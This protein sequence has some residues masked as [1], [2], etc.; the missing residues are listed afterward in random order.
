[1]NLDIIGTCDF[2]D[3]N[4]EIE[5]V[6]Q[7]IEGIEKALSD[8]NYEELGNK[9]SDALDVDIDASNI[10][11]LTSGYKELENNL[12]DLQAVSEKYSEAV[13]SYTTLTEDLLHKQAA[14]NEE[15]ARAASV[16]DGD[17]M[18]KCSQELQDLEEATQNA[19]DKMEEYSSLQDEVQ[20]KIAAT[21]ERLAQMKSAASSDSAITVTVQDNGVAGVTQN[22]QELS[23]G[24]EDLRTKIASAKDG[25]TIDLSGASE[26]LNKIGDAL[27]NV[28]PSAQEAGQSMSELETLINSA[29][30]MYKQLQDALANLQVGDT[31]Q[32][33]QYGQELETLKNVID[34]IN[35]LAND[36]ILV[37]GITDISAS[38]PKGEGYGVLENNPDVKFEIGNTP[39]QMPY[40]A[41]QIN[42][43]NAAQETALEQWQRMKDAIQASREEY[44]RFKEY[45]VTGEDDS[46]Q[47]LANNNDMLDSIQAHQEATSKE[48]EKT[49][50]VFRAI[51]G[52]IKALEDKNKDLQ[53][54][55]ARLKEA[56]ITAGDEVM[57]MGGENGQAVAALMKSPLPAI[58]QSISDNDA[59]IKS[60]TDTLLEIAK[61][62]QEI[63][64]ESQVLGEKADDIKRESADI[65]IALKNASAAPKEADAA[66]EQTVEP[67]VERFGKLKETM[68]ELGGGFGQVLG[69]FKKL[70]SGGAGAVQGIEMITAGF[71]QMGAAFLANPI[72]A[73][74]A[75]IVVAFKQ[76][77]D[78]FKRN[79]DAMGALRAVAAPFKAVWQSIQRLFDDIVKTITKVIN[80][81]RETAGASKFFQASL[82]PI[83]NLIAKLRTGLA[84]LGT[85]LVDISKAIRVV[86]NGFVAFKNSIANLI[87]GTRFGQWVQGIKDSIQDLFNSFFS[88]VERLANSKLGK[89]LGLD[90]LYNQIK[91]IRGAQD[92]L[93]EKNKEISDRELALSKRKRE[94]MV[95]EAELQAEIAKLNKQYQDAAG[96][97]KKQAEIAKQITEKEKAIKK[98]NLDIAK[99]EYELIKMRNSLIQA[100]PSQ[101]DEEA[102]AQADVIR[103]QSEYDNTMSSQESGIKRRSKNE[104]F[105]ENKRQLEAERDQRLEAFKQQKIDARDNRDE[106]QRIDD[107]EFKYKQE[108]QKK[109]LAL[110]LQYHKIQQSEYDTHLAKLVS[111]EETH[112]KQVASGNYDYF[113]NARRSLEYGVT[114][115]GKQETHNMEI[116]ALQT[117]LKYEKDTGKQLEIQEQ[118]RKKNLDWTIQQIELEKKKKILEVYKDEG[119]RQY[120]K[121][122]LNDVA[123]V[124]TEYDA[125]IAQ[126]TQKSETEDTRER[127]QTQL[128]NFEHYMQERLRIVNEYN[129]KVASVRNDMNLSPGQQQEQIALADETKNNQMAR[130]NQQF[131]GVTDEQKALVEQIVQLRTNVTMGALQEADN[132]YS[133]LIKELKDSIAEIDAEI[134]ADKLAIKDLNTQESDID[135]QLERGTKTVYDEDGNAQEVT[136]TEDERNV[137]LQQRNEIVAARLELENEINAALMARQE[138]DDVLQQTET[139][140]AEVAQQKLDQAARTDALK[141]ASW[142]AASKSMDAVSKSANAIQNIF[143][144]RMSASAKKTVAAIAGI[145][146]ATKQGIDGLAPLAQKLGKMFEKT[147]EQGATA[148]AATATSNTGAQATMVGTSVVSAATVETVSTTTTTAIKAVESA[149][150][151][152][153]IISVAIQVIQ[154][155]VEA[156]R[157]VIKTDAEVIQESI[158]KHKENVEELKYQNEQL[159]RSYKDEVGVEYYEH[160]TAAVKDSRRAIDEQK[161][162]VE[163]ARK[164]YEMQKDKHGEDSDKAKDAR[165]QYRELQGELNEMEDDYS[166]EMKDLFDTLLTTDLHSFSASLADS[167]VEGFE[168]GKDGIEQSW[169]DMLD[170]LLRD[171][172]K[173]QLA[174]ALEKQF[175][176]VFKHMNDLV[177]DDGKLSMQDIAAI[178]AEMEVAG[179]GAK[180][181][182]EGFYDMMD[183][184]NLLQDADVEADKGGFQSMSQDTADELNARFTALQ[185]E[186]ANV[187]ES[188][189]AMLETIAIMQGNSDRQVAL[190]QSIET[191]QL[192]A[193]QQAEERIDVIRAIRDNIELIVTNTN[194][195][196]AIEQNT[197]RL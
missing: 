192:S 163:D 6:T 37:K 45:E 136:L 43:T 157:Q 190:L 16:Q 185:I 177:A 119:L 28:A 68:A 110:Q 144:G 57:A 109:I 167:L 165:D 120:E 183:S 196:S 10:S 85:L 188:T 116:S 35:L 81:F 189:N 186:G 59:A 153:A 13:S 179:E 31:S 42:E 22:L 8:L 108:I 115:Q 176:D 18:V 26:Q 79:E 73:V 34:Q 193:Y 154:A 129:Q 1:M 80:N 122:T 111:E 98:E 60:L 126:A 148:A 195:L 23:V 97:T 52:Q 121:G 75:L 138:Q 106:L 2:T 191:Y 27:R 156:L 62:R 166:D 33:T 142:G 102:R 50:D 71:K 137:L 105:Q 158:D 84:I 92:E 168:N 65:R 5:S 173:Q 70:K 187:V 25:T 40:N 44:E 178:Q 174:L 117:Q 107:E 141:V 145:A 72:G 160:M 48:Y 32:I 152:L 131:S 9:L 55:C 161:K 56:G 88:W 91:E 54:E 21:T 78:A 94:S 86:V 87:A 38:V 20:A 149:S 127:L 49:I 103:K 132:L 112:R 182:A 93:S 17:T 47:R 123:G 95:K 118:I 74:I 181:I 184:M 143:G 66:A 83:A 114:Q 159:K 15:F 46:A 180:Q 113:K 171:M 125:R 128:S 11:D 162:A 139:A 140:K 51:E 67:T 169:D 3:V 41:E 4:K 53:A 134:N 24:L 63:E 101:K 155:I 172:M 64:K 99:E 77:V 14:L 135:S 7:K 69:G 147:A 133:Q 150:V 124:T 96:D 170:N 197:S 175:E 100:T 30:G 90:E 39:D 58:E 89:K 104:E 12:T 164:L 146:D 151:I 36:S 19:F 76:L 194:R 130:L 82:T 61:R 29:Q